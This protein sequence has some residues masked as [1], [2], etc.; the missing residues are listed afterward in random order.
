MSEV[1]AYNRDNFPFAG[2]F[3][4]LTEKA[5]RYSQT[6]LEAYLWY[7]KVRQFRGLRPGPDYCSS[8]ITSGGHARCPD[9]DSLAVIKKNTDTAQSYMSELAMAAV[10]HAKHVILPA[11]LG[12][13]P[14]WRQSDYITMWLA[15]IG[16]IDLGLGTTNNNAT[17]FEM[18]LDRQLDIEEVDLELMN[19]SSMTGF[20]RAIQYFKFAGAFTTA[21][22][23]LD[24]EPHSV[25][26]II[27]LVD[28]ELSLGSRT[29]RVFAHT[30]GIPVY[31]VEVAGPGPLAY[32]AIVNPVLRQDLELIVKYGAAS[33]ELLPDNKFVLRELSDID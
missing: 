9:I 21:T 7:Q 4:D 13:I 28:T 24:R 22:A 10:I 1:L 12:Y 26:R 2:V 3:E 17:R 19:N 16:G 8:S 31:A 23:T 27:N 25:H 29:E 30:K 11:D 14:H 15:T 6:P 32:D 20:E 18:A 5:N 33:V